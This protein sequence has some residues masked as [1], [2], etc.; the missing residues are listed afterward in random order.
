M[1]GCMYV[2]THIIYMRSLC[3]YVYMYVCLNV[4]TRVYVYCL[5]VRTYTYIVHKWDL[6]M[7]PSAVYINF[8]VVF[9]SSLIEH[10]VTS[11]T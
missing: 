6:H 3:M 10:G 8:T 11:I 5:R 7:C 2:C 1:Y 4:R 9:S